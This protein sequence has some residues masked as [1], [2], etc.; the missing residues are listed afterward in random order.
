MRMTQKTEEGER[1]Q[2]AIVKRASSN[3][4]KETVLI[5]PISID[6]THFSQLSSSVYLLFINFDYLIKSNFV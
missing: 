3:K 1:G 4:N 2:K 5:Q 6:S